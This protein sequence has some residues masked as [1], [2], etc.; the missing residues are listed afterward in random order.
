MPHTVSV[1]FILVFGDAPLRR[2]AERE[3]IALA[4]VIKL[5]VTRDIEEFFLYVVQNPQIQI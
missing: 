4:E 3:H 1:L 2:S 5:H